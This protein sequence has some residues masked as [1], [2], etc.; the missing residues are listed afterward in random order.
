MTDNTESAAEDLSKKITEAA[1][2]VQER[3]PAAAADLSKGMQAA[4]KE[5]HII[6]L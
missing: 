2:A 3:G 5:V 4:A 6:V 1:S